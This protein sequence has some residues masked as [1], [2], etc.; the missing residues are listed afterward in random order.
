MKT[1][2]IAVYP[3]DGIGPEVTDEAVRVLQAVSKL[4][5]SFALNLTTF[6]WGFNYWEQHGHVVPG[7]FIDVLR[8]FDAILLGA[9]GWPEKLPAR[10]CRRGRSSTGTS[11]R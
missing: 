1:L 4:D 2:D 3:G 8:P 9:V 10:G 6:P 5:G 7:D 11:S